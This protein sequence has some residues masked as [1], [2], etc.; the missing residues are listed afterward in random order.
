MTMFYAVIFTIIV[1]IAL[2][3][4]ILVKSRADDSTETVN[5]VNVA[6]T[7]DTIYVTTEANGTSN[8]TSINGL[9][10]A[11]N[12]RLY[13]HGQISDANGCDDVA[14][15]GTVQ[16]VLFRTA[17]GNTCSSANDDECIR[18]TSLAAFSGC[19]PDSSDL[20]ANYNMTVDLPYYADP[21]G[22]GSGNSSDSWSAYVEIA[23]SAANADTDSSLEATM[24]VEA[25]VAVALSGNVSYGT[26]ALGAD[27]TAQ[28]LR[29]TN[30]GNVT[31][32]A[33][34]LA[35]GPMVCNGAGSAD[36]VAS[37]TAVT[38]SNSGEWP[39]FGFWVSNTTTQTYALALAKRTPSTASTID[40]YLKLRMPSTGILGT[41]SNVLTFTANNVN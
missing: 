40:T 38:T 30:T 4:L 27:S 17:A 14:T 18:T 20:T 28:N 24:E 19:T 13:V 31:I 3:S 2:V 15:S 7:I 22:A 29:F 36:I 23:D 6:P 26:V 5:P 8:I 25:N 37:Q 32:D 9:G 34:V 16:I 10:D 12:Q 39:D 1:C 11:T 33:D 21:T 41:C 35:D